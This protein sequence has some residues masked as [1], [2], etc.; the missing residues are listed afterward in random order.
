MVGSQFPK[1]MG[2][3]NLQHENQ[4]ESQDFYEGWLCR[5]GLVFNV[6]Y[7]IIECCK[8]R[9]KETTHTYS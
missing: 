8:E 2:C 6:V 1:V 3:S 5:M 7:I 9:M 4:S